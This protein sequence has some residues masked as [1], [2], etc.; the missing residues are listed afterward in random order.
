MKGYMFTLESGLACIVIV[1]F[2]VFLAKIHAADTGAPDPASLAYE[3]LRA[4]DASGMLR[5][6]AL[7]SDYSGLNSRV[8]IR[9]YNHS[10][11]ICGVGGACQGPDPAAPDI[12]TASYLVAGSGQYKPM[13]VR[14][15]LWK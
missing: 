6:Y 13:E 10:I 9:S 7:S 3:E 4:L 14:L 12:W 15:Y 2:I 1:S 8:Q 5:P 11:K